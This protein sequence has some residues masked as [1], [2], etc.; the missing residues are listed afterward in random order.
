MTNK[1]RRRYLVVL[2]VLAFAGTAWLVLW[3]ISS[4]H[5]NFLACPDGFSILAD[6]PECRR[7]KLLEYGALISFIGGVVL[8][9]MA[10]RN[11]KSASRS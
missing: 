10:V 6:Q 3:S 8:T 7:P 2:A 5:M 4:A 1:H 11:R 9:V